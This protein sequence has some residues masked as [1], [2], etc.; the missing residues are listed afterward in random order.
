VASVEPGIGNALVDATWPIEETVLADADHFMQVVDEQEVEPV[1]AAPAAVL[2]VAPPSEPSPTPLSWGELF[3]ALWLLGAALGLA[4]IV[5]GALRLRSQLAGRRPIVAPW[6]LH[7]LQ[8]APRVGLCVAP[9]LRVPLVYGVWRPEVCV[10]ARALIELDADA[11]RAIVAH[12]LGHVVHRDP[13]WRWIGL[14]LERVLFFQPLLRLANRE[15]T[16]ASELLADAWA[17]ERTRRP[18]ALAE[19][20]TVVAAWVRPRAFASPAPA[21]AGQRSQLRRRVE[22][23]VEADAT[24]IVDPWPRWL[25]PGLTIAVAGLVA[26]APGVS[27]QAMCPRALSGL[28]FDASAYA[29]WVQADAG[30]GPTV[31]VLQGDDFESE[32]AVATDD[33]KSDRKSTR[34]T[35][36]ERRK[37]KKRVKQAFKRARKRGDVPTDAELVAAL[38]GN[39]GKKKSASDGSVVVVIGKDGRKAVVRVDAGALGFQTRD[40]E[41]QLGEAERRLRHEQRRLEARARAIEQLLEAERH[42]YGVE[43]YLRYFDHPKHKHKHK[44]KKHKHKGEHPGRGHGWGRGG[45]VAAPPAPPDPPRPVRAPRPPRPAHPPRPPAA[46]I[47]PLPPAP[48]NA[49]PVVWE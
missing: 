37:A 14:L 47:A 33:D 15:L 19:S 34:A 7:E 25:A 20:L 42:G 21:M 36:K 48:P 9:N 31:I 8:P 27:A 45:V 30:D 6:G 22:R 17:V 13:L 10:P 4:G 29:A 39:A 23:L 41:R 3:G 32:A 2:E 16:A 18:L 12:E 26:F 24:G 44:A 40:V 49:M 43:E 38:R 28:E 46:G 1:L 5:A 11:L 35:A